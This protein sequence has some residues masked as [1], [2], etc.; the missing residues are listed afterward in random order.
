MSNRTV[1]NDGRT[2][3]AQ[4]PTPGTMSSGGRTDGGSPFAIP[5]ISLPKGGGAIRGIGEKFA[6]NP[7][8]GSGSM[9][10]P[11]AVSAGRSSFGPQL[12]LAYS[13]GSG[14][15]PFG[16]GWSLSL[17]SI[18]RKTDKGIPRYQDVREDVFILSGAED[19]VPVRNPD[20]TLVQAD[21]VGYRITRYRPRVE[22]L[23]ARI[24]RWTRLSDGDTHWRSI[25]KENL[26]TIYGKDEE[27]R[28]AD[29]QD[30]R[31]V[32][33]WLICETRDDKGD[34]IVYEYTAE[35]AVNVDLSQAHERHRGPAGSILR[36]ANRYPKRILY[37][38]RQSLL[39]D[40]TRRPE[41]LSADQRENADW[42]FEVVFDY[43]DEHYN[44]LPEDLQKRRFI[45]ASL[46]EAQAKPWPVRSDPFSSYRAGFEVRTY[47][48][49]RRVLLF[50]HFPDRLEV[51]DYLVRS[52][53]FTFRETPIASFI[54]SVTQSGYVRQANGTWLKR[55][56]PVLEFEYSEAVIEERVREIS[57]ES[58]ENL[59]AGVDA[60]TY[61]WIDLDGDG[62]GGILSEQGGAWFYKRNLSPRNEVLEDGVARTVA[63][64]A[65]IETVAQLPADKAIRDGM[66]FVDLAADGMPDL[67]RFDGPAP[68]FY[69]H[70]A[71][72][73]WS[74]HHPF[75]SLPDI[76]WRDPNLKFIDLT[77]DGH[78]DVLISED[79][80][81]T[82][83]PS[84]AEAGFDAC[85]RALQPL[86]EDQGPRLV[87]AETGQSIYLADLSGDGLTD[88]V[89]VRNGEVC[90]W[91][92]LGYGRFGAKVA[93]DGA[94]VFDR[95]DQFDQ[96]RIRLAD[97]DG[98]GVTDIVYLHGDGVRVY[99][100]QSG[101]GW[102]EAKQL[103]VFPRT[104][105]LSSVGAF[106]LLGNGTACLVWSSSLPGH[107]RQSMCYVDLMGGLKPHLLISSRNNLG[108]ETRMRY[109]P[110]T[111]FYLEDKF[112]GRPWITRLPFP[113]QVVER[114]E[115][116]DR[117][118]NSRFV[119]RF[120]YHH[121]YFDAEEREFRGFGMVEQQDTE[122][123]TLTGFD[124][125]DAA[126]HVPPVLTRT[127]FHTG[128]F[129]DQGRISQQFE[130]EYY[131]EGDE[132][133]L[134]PDTILPDAVTSDE[135][136]EAC[137]ALKGSILRQEVYAF[138]GREES[139][140]PYTVSE[141]NYTIEMLQPRQGNRHAVFFAHPREQIDFHYDR[142]LVEVN[143]VNRADPR[144][145]HALT[146][147]VDPFGNALRTLSIGYRRRALPG[148]NEP[149]QKE[150]HLVLMANRF[151]NR[152]DEPD[153]FRAGLGVEA[154]TYEIVKPPEPQIAGARIVPFGFEAMRSLAATLFP[155]EHTE[156][157]NAKL[158]PYENWD[159][160]VNP[161][162]A[163]A[164]TRLRLI[165]R[166]RTLYRRD[167]LTSLLPA[168]SVES[169]AVLG[170]KYK[171]AL[172]TA[173]LSGVYKRVQPPEDFLP[174]PAPLLEGKAS[175]QGGYVALDGAWWVP[176]GSMFFGADADAT[177]P[178]ATA[179]QER[180]TARQGFFQP[181]KFVDAFGHASTVE[182]D[183]DRF[184]IVATQDPL[185][186]RTESTSDY[187]VLQPAIIRDPNRNRTAAAFDGLGLVVATAVTGKSGENAGDRL[188]GFETDPPLAALQ[189]FAA[190]PRGQAASLVGR[191]TT[192]IVYDL[193]RFR[194]CGQPP[195]AAAM[196]RET[197]FFDAGGA[198][199]KIQIGVS[200]SDGFGRE[201]QKKVQAE[202]GAAPQ[203]LPGAPLPSGDTQPGPLVRDAEGKP[204][205]ANTVT[206]WAGTGRTVF[207]NKGAPVRQYE[208]FFS[209][210]HLYE[211]ERDMTDTGV[212]P[213]LFYDPLGRQIATLHP[214][215]TY[216]KAVFDPWRQTTYDVNDTVTASGSETG[217]PRT[218]E[219]IAGYVAE[220]FR[221]QPNTWQTW[222]A[223]RIGNQLGPAELDAA[224]KA[225]A[226]AN[227]PSVAHLDAL[228]RAFLT[229]A[230]NGVDQNQVPRRHAT[231]ARRDIEGNTRELLDAT[232]RIGMR[233]DYDLLGT[234]IHQSGM[235]A[236]ERWM[237]IDVSGKPIRTWDS[238]RFVRRMGYDELRRPAALFVT[239][240]GVERLAERTVY[241]E[242]LGDADNHRTRARQVFDGAGVV[243]VDA[244]DFKGN[245]L[246]SRRELLPGYKQGV[247]WQQN[248]AASGGTFTLLA[249][250]DALNRPLT[251][252]TPD[253]SVYRPAFNEAN[254]LE[255]VQVNLRGAAASTAFVTGIDY[256][257]KGQREAIVYGNGAQ[258][259]YEYD[260]MT[261]RLKRLTTTRPANPDA[262]ASQL[263][264]NATLTQDLRYTYDPVGN[265][266]RIED[267]ALKT[268]FN[269]GEQVEPVSEYAYD[270]VYR[271]IEARGREHI[272][273][274]VFD[275]DPPADARRDFPYFGTQAN[276]N[277]LQAMRKYT[278]RYEYDEAGNFAS[279]QHAFTG[280]GWNRGY[281]Y[282]EA[283]LIE[284][285]K[286]GNRLTRTTTG[287]LVEAYSYDDAQGADVHGC[288]TSINALAMA[289]DF[290]DQLQEVDLGGGGTAYFVYDAGGQRVRK[291]IE[292]QNGTR[293]HERIYLHGFEVYREFENDGDT[294]KLER[295]T[296]H[297]A[298]DKKRIALIE[299]RTQGV[300]PGI[301]PQLIR[302]QF[303]NHL[304][305][306][307]MELDQ[308]ALLISYEE[309]QPYGTTSFQTARSAAE[310]SLK[311]YRHTGKE[312][313]DETG[314]YYHVA[315]YYAPWLGRWIS[316]DP[317]GIADDANLYRYVAGNPVTFID[318][319]G[320][321]HESVH[322]YTTFFIAMSA[323]YSFEDASKIATYANLPDEWDPLDSVT[324]SSREIFGAADND[325]SNL[326]G[327][328]GRRVVNE[329]IHAFDSGDSPTHSAQQE[330]QVRQNIIT[331][332][333]RELE[334]SR[335]SRGKGDE[336]LFAEV[337]FGVHALG[338]AYAHST[339]ED[340]SHRYGDVAGHGVPGIGKG[341]AT[342]FG[343]GGSFAGMGVAI[344]LTAMLP[345][346]AIAL[347]II[348]GLIG[349]ALGIYVM[350]DQ[351]PAPD[352]PG[353]RPKLFGEY[354]ERLMTAFLDANGKTS[355]LTAAERDE[356]V[357]LVTSTEDEEE[358]IKIIRAQ[359]KRHFGVDMPA[360]AP[361]KTGATPQLSNTPNVSQDPAL[362]KEAAKSNFLQYQEAL[363]H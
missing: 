52:T 48:L 218:D 75:D 323:G 105:S 280:G 221:S 257:A 227:T 145:S 124:N 122:Q 172:T 274:T 301:P 351:I 93:M 265:I 10:V 180:V 313:D 237:L 31:R 302:Y 317:I 207:N 57:G 217:D 178:A 349:I 133:D 60:S 97:I 24:E 12:S 158:W 134:L 151:A 63:Q 311:R 191:A 333:G 156:P 83:Y 177:N 169:Q 120:V 72:G 307:S 37:G 205:Q 116:R 29:P 181:R 316:C 270:P 183:E 45:A 251:V 26:L 99:F 36:T 272:G 240:N 9:T 283:S 245:L 100:N 186:N 132:S 362:L 357:R 224:Q 67:A 139:D 102:S 175:D 189:S 343:A 353:R 287:G 277:D 51:P 13:S 310:A 233:Y 231:R 127:W 326:P 21:R 182:Y 126:S 135:T 66:Q 33:S 188:D 305:S 25:S 239:E 3:A 243:T 32:F 143:G 130:H 223:Q 128:A 278:Q 152:P 222:R 291:V 117:I 146:L 64:L 20:G 73:T 138:D 123:F 262:T 202:P 322:Y 54:A 98:S 279:V 81:F 174:D 258:T 330:R 348:G 59:P 43:G 46:D 304:G 315:R 121:G 340:E 74:S 356:F 244:Y 360:Y 213:V 232:N 219:D 273:Q 55:S 184:L 299:T 361:E 50:H 7:V 266:T 14:N 253:N 210:T 195:F 236:G 355:K 30:K 344:G 249:V 42:M 144:V 113:V 150:T 252:T 94:P 112:A 27:S 161:G 264:T 320:T 303:G 347:G 312:R 79:G 84:R 271:L 89:R 155:L 193:D 318:P 215:H 342:I 206:R 329:G 250:Y 338:D 164:D 19:L 294:V 114:I 179:A 248:P 285:A 235:D 269:A 211:D 192:R 129:F 92:N 216:E 23:F 212:S 119:T 165:E 35:D 350:L 1:E 136:L 321:Y 196:A 246:R 201:I 293:R 199:S 118:S 339:L 281:D 96:R 8:T 160:R 141:R 111:K 194:R 363:S 95:P 39:D 331:S 88:I 234:R 2:A 238:R 284:P 292:S 325:S 352:N 22:G 159:W 140:R 154:H 78:A 261:Q 68:G 157:E 167:D 225:S 197:H 214:N 276:P 300:E 104:D 337:G 268:I 16:L 58:L 34:G 106:D 6:A 290:E 107:A 263:F 28:I 334:Q 109:A 90:Y 359:F 125:D 153:W 230:D 5:S 259:N 185:G 56:L 297:V 298:D 61:R 324:Y 295:E 314:F 203:R 354:V 319:T 327:A 76:N 187:R 77:G 256:N 168:G 229:I 101:N 11:I 69:E 200:Y 308:D 103:A 85:E 137:R 288:I 260:P 91:P 282:E 267:P 87:F 131:R 41:F 336:K 44:E 345:P 176:L 148:V 65:P 341:L 110:S 198:Q 226:H 170:A 86:D 80:V 4:G 171:L 332:K 108:A 162:H 147:E 49:C 82:W 346:L 18:T 166:I 40:D 70:A 163:P 306:A 62:V 247:D 358:Q 309:Y 275:F 17:P 289:W 286:V 335:D 142:V 149:E 209:A 228:G 190:D 241:G 38:S 254:L 328:L 242:A 47:R 220:Y 204:A 71:D 53:E 173:L 255:S 15:G 208:P 115:T 296:L